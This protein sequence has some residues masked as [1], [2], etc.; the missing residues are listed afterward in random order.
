[1]ET[2]P[3]AG[4]TSGTLEAARRTQKARRQAG[5]SSNGRLAK[6]DDTVLRG[7]E[8]GLIYDHRNT[9]EAFYDTLP[10][11]RHPTQQNGRPDAYITQHTTRSLA[12]PPPSE[13]ACPRASPNGDPVA[14]RCSLSVTW[15]RRMALPV[16]D[17]IAWPPWIMAPAGPRALRHSSQPDLPRPTLR[18]LPV[19]VVLLVFHRLRPTSFPTH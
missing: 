3:R 5:P 11:H 13:T 9:Y 2:G 18:S 4:E 14:A 17:G 19:A 10:G 6:A 7:S 15:R 16:D 12:S 1:M 8:S